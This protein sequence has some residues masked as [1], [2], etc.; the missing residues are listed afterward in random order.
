MGGI[1]PMKAEKK[2]TY[3]VYAFRIST[4]KLEWLKRELDAVVG[5]VNRRKAEDDKLIRKNDVIVEALRQGFRSIRAEHGRR[6]RG[7]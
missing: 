7:R 4:E 2:G 6:G 3:P 5:L 1:E